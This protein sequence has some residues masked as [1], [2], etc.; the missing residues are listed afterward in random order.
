MGFRF[1]VSGFRVLGFRVKLLGLRLGPYRGICQVSA[2]LP[3]FI[4]TLQRGLASLLQGLQ[5]CEGVYEESAAISDSRRPYGSALGGQCLG[6]C[7][8]V[9]QGFLFTDVQ[10]LGEYSRLCIKSVNEETPTIYLN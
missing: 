9:Q 6:L 5:M 3:S 1:R 2:G 7:L 4:R 8:W 10:D